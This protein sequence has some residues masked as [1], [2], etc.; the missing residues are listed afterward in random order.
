[1]DI[2]Y[3]DRTVLLKKLWENTITASYFK[4]SGV[5]SPE[6]R[7]FIGYEFNFD[8]YCG[9]PIK[10]NLTDLS[11]VNYRLYDRDAGEGKIVK[12]LRQQK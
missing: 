5:K 6:Y 2:S 4:Y 1:M 9:R 12:E 3:L 7:D 10:M 8:Y 11:N